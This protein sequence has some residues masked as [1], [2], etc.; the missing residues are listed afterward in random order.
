MDHYREILQEEFV[1]RRKKNSSYSL[2][3]FARDIQ[4]TPTRLSQVLRGRQGLSK[5]AADQIADR[6]GFS[7]FMKAYFCAHVE[8]EHGR[9]PSARAAAQKELVRL[10]NQIHRKQL[11]RKEI[12]LLSH[13]YYQSILEL[14]QLKNFRSDEAW[15]ARVLNVDRLEIRIA[16]RTLKDLGLLTE[17]NGTLKSIPA[18]S[19]GPSSREK[20]SEALRN[21]HLELNSLARKMI[22][23][24]LSKEKGI[25]TQTISMDVSKLDEFKQKI[26][27][28]SREFAHESDLLANKEEVYCLYMQIFPLSQAR[29]N[30]PHDI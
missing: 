30:K 12:E 8:S 15:I 13:W 23:K 3:A 10:G 22:E 7:S 6:L 27:Q 25:L 4:I 17:N 20:R 9:N 16:L 11:P 14:T 24:P 19:M 2:R 26:I 1:R 28:F 21:N 5:A 18:T 29:E